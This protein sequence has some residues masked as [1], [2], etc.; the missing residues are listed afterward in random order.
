MPNSLQFSI[1]SAVQ[2]V[3]NA[4]NSEGLAIHTVTTTPVVQHT[5]GL[6]FQK[7]KSELVVAGLNP[8]TGRI[9][10]KNLAE[11]LVSGEVSL[12]EGALLH[13]IFE[14]FPAKLRRMSTQEASELRMVSVF[15]GEDCSQ[16]W[17]ILWP[18]LDGYFPGSPEVSET[19][20]AMQDICLI[21]QEP[22]SEA[23]GH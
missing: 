12:Q 15:L 1:E 22:S 4:L 11:K 23:P 17:Q 18:D 13:G 9:V 6:S 14:Q 2:S 10:L 8:Q 21:M 20:A 16:A 3:L 5:V 19:F 7:A